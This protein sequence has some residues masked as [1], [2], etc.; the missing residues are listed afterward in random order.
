MPYCF[1]HLETRGRKFI[2]LPLNRN[3]KP[4][5]QTSDKWVNYG[6]YIDQAVIFGSDPASFKNIWYSNNDAKQFYLYSDSSISRREYF[7]RLG[8][9]MSKAPKIVTPPSD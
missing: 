4:L 8:R 2:Y 1:Q 3:Y 7:E 6:K 9:L 5:G